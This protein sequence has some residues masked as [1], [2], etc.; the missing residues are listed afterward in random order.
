MVTLD[1]FN[2]VLARAI[3]DLVDHS[4]LTDKEKQLVRARWGLDDGIFKTLDACLILLNWPVT[5]ER[6]RQIEAKAMRKMRARSADLA[7]YMDEHYIPRLCNRLNMV[8]EIIGPYLDKL[9]QVDADRGDETD[10]GRK[11]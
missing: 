5:R 11:S 2:D 9:D 8:R 10:D 6:T 3:A 1:K 4:D 7:L